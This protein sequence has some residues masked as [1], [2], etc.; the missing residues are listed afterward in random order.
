MSSAPYFANL[1]LPDTLPENV[2]DWTPQDVEVFLRANQNRGRPADSVI[3]RLLEGG[4]NGMDLC[5]LA[6]AR[7]LEGLFNFPLG[8]CLDLAKLVTSLKETKGLP[9]S[10]PG[11]TSPAL[12]FTDTPPA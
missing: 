4:V 2:F 3:Q 7:M 5:D 9:L 12:T 11:T 1:K 8:Q 10:G 6:D